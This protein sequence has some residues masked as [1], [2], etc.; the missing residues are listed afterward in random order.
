MGALV[1]FS[2]N[3]REWGQQRFILNLPQ[4]IFEPLTV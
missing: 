1:L 2:E 3:V 4:F